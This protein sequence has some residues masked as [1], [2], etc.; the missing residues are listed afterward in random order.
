[1]TLTLYSHPLASFCHKVLIALYEAGTQFDPILVD[2]SDPGDHAR[3]LDMWPVGKMP[4][5]RDD[6]RNETIPEA[7]II[8][9]YLDHHYPGSQA[10]LPTDPETCLRARLWDRFF[11]LYVQE[12]MQKIVFD[13]FRP[14][15]EKDKTGVEAAE[16]RLMQA[17]D[18]VEEHMSDKTWAAGDSFSIAECSAAPALFFAGIIVPFKFNQSALRGYFERLVDRPSFRR[19][20]VEAQPYFEN[21]PFHDRVPEHFLTITDA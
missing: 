4:V 15:D 2:L 16:Q 21:F 6:A 11:D 1:M 5:L 18:M 3:F 20:L 7:S 14:D 19:V 13:S 17:Y 9:E 8:I 12:P 10:M